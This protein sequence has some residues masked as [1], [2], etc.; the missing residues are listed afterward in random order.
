MHQ[1]TLRK[2][3]YFYMLPPKP[4]LMVSE[5]PETMYLGDA[6]TL[7]DDKTAKKRGRISKVYHTI[8]GPFCYMANPKAEH[9]RVISNRIGL[10][11]VILAT[12]GLINNVRE[13]DQTLITNLSVLPTTIYKNV[14]A[15]NTA[16]ASI[17]QNY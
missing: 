17:T 9:R 14:Q 8:T 4:I 5:S 10:S 12:A 11:L 3:Q 7:E 13:T 16:N 15:Y 6:P 2:T 1:E